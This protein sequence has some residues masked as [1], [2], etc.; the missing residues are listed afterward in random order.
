MAPRSLHLHR[1]IPK[2]QLRSVRKRVIS[3][4]PHAAAG[5]QKETD[6]HR[7]DHPR[8]GKAAWKAARTRKVEDPIRLQR[9]EDRIK[10]AEAEDP[11]KL[12]KVVDDRRKRA[13]V[14]VQPKATEDA[15]EADRPRWSLHA[16]SRWH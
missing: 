3:L 8:V 6:V 5:L 4:I 12:Q 1:A 11:T 10:L 7:R 9:V 13:I 15:V 14:A 16:P 2:I